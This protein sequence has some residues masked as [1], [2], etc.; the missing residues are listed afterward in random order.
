[1][2]W[3]SVIV[4]VLALQR[5]AVTPYTFAII[6]LPAFFSYYAMAV[7]VQLPD[8]RFYRAALLPIVFWMSFR[9]NM[10]LDFTWNYAGYAYLNQGLS[11]GMFTIA[12]RSTAWVLAERPYT[13]LP[14]YKLRNGTVNGHNGKTPTEHDFSVP[15]ALWNAWDLTMNLRG[16]GWDGPQRIHIPT[17]YFRV[18][19]R[20]I[21]AFLSFSRLTFLALALDTLSRSVRS[22]GPATFGTPKGGTIFDPLLPP[23]ERYTNS[24]VITLLSGT[25]AYVM[26]EATYQLHAV[27]F[28]IVFQQYPSQW[29][30][31]FDSPWLST[32]L[33]SLWGRRWHQLFRECFVVVGSKPMEK[34]L[35]RAGTVMGAFAISG[36][37]HDIGM[38]GMGRG[39]DT[40]EVVGFFLLH[41]VGVSMEH[42]WKK[43]TGRRVGG[44]IGWLWVFFWLVFWGQVV[45]DVWARRGLI[46][47]EFFHAP[48]R[49]TTLILNWISRKN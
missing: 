12:M 18:E 15:S 25:T 45:V 49:P 22:F 19:S 23:L 4:P 35:G 5:L 6:F 27:V 24:F 48:Y 42:A 17:P 29:P 26:I 7:L 43:A 41:G 14:I 34:Y 1:M 38:R 39:G 9:A 31:L 21:F 30:P 44:I 20:P 46:G 28:T 13:R 3:S 32:S 8:T 47:S 11:L 33:I 16:I 36:L 37:L 2:S 40:A 10:S